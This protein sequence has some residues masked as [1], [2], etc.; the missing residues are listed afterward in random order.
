MLIKLLNILVTDFTIA[1]VSKVPIKTNIITILYLGSISV[2][3]TTLSFIEAAAL[4]FSV[5]YGIV[6]L[7][8]LGHVIMAKSY[9]YNTTEICIN[10]LGGVASI[11]DSEK[12]SN[13]QMFFV[14]WAGP[15]VNIALTPILYY[16][17][18]NTLLMIN[19]IMLIF[20]LL[21]FFP[22]DG[23]RI[24]KSILGAFVKNP[25]T[26]AYITL[27]F[28]IVSFGVLVGLTFL[29]KN[30]IYILLGVLL[31]LYNYVYIRQIKAEQKS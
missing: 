2:L 28:A 5:F 14:A 25:L 8:E 3:S 10:P 21:P 12:M 31:L 23:G 24:I 6:L 22:M 9:G 15:A 17:G 29:S 4:L 19:V 20:N 11:P 16:T 27:G 30:P 26:L 18:L 1:K 7:H 13:R